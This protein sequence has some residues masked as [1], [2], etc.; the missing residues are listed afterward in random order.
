M[1]CKFKI[2]P[3][4]L[5]SALFL[6]ALP[7]SAKSVTEEMA[8][9]ALAAA[10]SKLRRDRDSVAGRQLLDFAL[11]VTPENENALLLQAKLERDLPFDTLKYSRGMEEYIAFLKKVIAGTRAENRKLLLYKVIEHI[12]PADEQ[13]LL[14]LTKAKNAGTETDFDKLLEQLGGPGTKP[15][16]TE[17]TPSHD[18]P[19]PPNKP[20]PQPPAGST[21]QSITAEELYEKLKSHRIEEIKQFR[22]K[23]VKVSGIVSGIGKT[24]G[25][26]YV[27]LNDGRI[28]MVLS[29]DITTSKVEEVKNEY[30]TIEK[31]LQQYKEYGYT[32]SYTYVIKF[33]GTGKCTGMR[34]GYV[35]I[36][37]CKDISWHKTYVSNP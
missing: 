7:A 26:P 9:G 2:I 33:T 22:D 34:G 15:T 19:R 14:A 18:A 5:M 27:F 36:E 8:D 25:K 3:W 10:S 17:H 28:R 32:P 24:F 16:G 1:L 35:I 11:F 6:S 4:I 23:D 20:D 21:A 30:S 37:D 13:T 29:K 31:R 12:N